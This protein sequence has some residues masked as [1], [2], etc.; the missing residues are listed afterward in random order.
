MTVDCQCDSRIMSPCSDWRDET[1]GLKNFS[2]VENIFSEVLAAAFE[3]ILLKHKWEWLNKWMEQRK[4]AKSSGPT[5]QSAPFVLSRPMITSEYT[6]AVLCWA[7]LRLTPEDSKK[8]WINK[9]I[10]GPRAGAGS[11]MQTWSDLGSAAQC[12]NSTTACPTVPSSSLTSTSGCGG[13][14]T[15]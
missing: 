4:D 13:V 10:W 7:S 14:L 1:S 5:W 9:T 15:S 12:T 11:T 8:S 6:T 2:A 3:I